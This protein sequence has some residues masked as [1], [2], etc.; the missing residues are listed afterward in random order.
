MKTNSQPHGLDELTA[1]CLG[2]SNTAPP[3]KPGRNDVVMEFETPGT[4][5]PLTFG[6]SLMYAESNLNL[7]LQK[8]NMA[9]D[10]P[11]KLSLNG[12]TSALKLEQNPDN[13]WSIESTGR[14]PFV[15]S[16]LSQKYDPKK[17]T[18]LQFEYKTE[19]DNAS[20]RIFFG[21]Q[22]KAE[23]SIL[24]PSLQAAGDWTTGTINLDENINYTEAGEFLPIHI[25]TAPR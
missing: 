6:V 8:S 23:N 7:P 17:L 19:T 21:P 24:L 9:G 25:W 22:L 13:S 4:D 11:V 3:L 12:K 20:V 18:A 10:G 15:W 2:F 1:V 14:D 16:N 5:S